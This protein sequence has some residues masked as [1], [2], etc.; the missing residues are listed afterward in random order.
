MKRRR[1]FFGKGKWQRLQPHR[2]SADAAKA[3]ASLPPGS[4]LPQSKCSRRREEAG[5]FSIRNPQSPIRNQECP[6][7]PRQAR[8]LELVETAAVGG[9][10]GARKRKVVQGFSPQDLPAGMKR[11]DAGFACKP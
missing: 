4:G 6:P 2:A 7:P 9:Y 1:I 5:C 11:A 10:E 3:E 8:G